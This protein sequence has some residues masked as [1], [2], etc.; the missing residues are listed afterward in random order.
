V[1]IDERRI[2]VDRELLDCVVSMAVSRSPVP[3]QIACGLGGGGPAL[4]HA[5]LAV[6]GPGKISIAEMG[7][8]VCYRGEE[9]CVVDCCEQVGL[10]KEIYRP[11]L[12][13][14][15]W[16][17]VLVRDTNPS[18]VS[19]AGIG[20]PKARESL[21]TTLLQS[22][23]P[24]S[25]DLIATIF[26]QVGCATGLIEDLALLDPALLGGSLVSRGQLLALPLMRRLRCEITGAEARAVL[27]I[28]RVLCLMDPREM[29][30]SDEWALL[31]SALSNRSYAISD[32]NLVLGAFPGLFSLDGDARRAVVRPSSRL[33]VLLLLGDVPV[34]PSEHFAI[35]KALRDRALAMLERKDTSDR[36]VA[37]QLPRQARAAA[38]LHDLV[39]DPL[40]VLC[41][42]PLELVRE[43][44]A[45]PSD[46][47]TPAGKIVALSS[48]R[49]ID[50]PDRASQLELSARRIGLH[51][52]ADELAELLPARRWRALWAQSELTHTHRVAFNHRAPLLAV[53]AVDHPEGRAY[54]GSADGRVWRVAPYRRPVCLA[55]S[56]ALSVEIRAIAAVRVADNDLVGVG[57][58]SHAVGVFDGKSGRLLW[59]D[60]TSHSD[61]VSAV[62]IQGDEEPILLSAGVGG[63]IFRH[64]MAA[65][66]EPL[67]IHEHGSEIRDLRTI[68][69]GGVELVV[70]CAVNGVV[71]VARLKDGVLVANWHL[72]DEV[73]NSVAV[74]LLVDELLLIAG[75]SDGSLRQLRLPLC[76]LDCATSDEPPARLEEWQRIGSHPLAVNRVHIVADGRQP[77]VLSGASDGSWQ[78]RHGDVEERAG[79]G[80]VGPIWSLDLIEA[81]NRRYVVTAGGEGACRLWLTDAVL[82]ERI[83]N[84][85]PLAHRGPVSAIQ[86]AA[87]PAEETLVVT[88][89]ADGDVRVAAR[90]L[91]EGGELLTRHDSGISALACLS[92]GHERS[93]VVSGS[94]DGTLRLTPVDGRRRQDSVVLGIAHE[95]IGALSV[96]M[97]EDRQTLISGGRDGTVTAWD[98]RECFADKTVQGCRYGGVQALCHIDDQDGGLL[99]VGGQE[100]R[101]GMLRGSGLEEQ[102][103]CSIETSVLCLS[104][105]PGASRTVLAG[106]VDGRIAVVRELGLY[107]QQVSY[108]QACENEIRG[109]G[110]LVLGGRVFVA[111][112]GLDRRLRLIDIQ[113]EEPTMDIEMDGYA[114]SLSAVGA[115]VGLGSSAGAAVICFPT[116]TLV[117]NQ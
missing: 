108:L 76:D 37:R 8:A 102:G 14:S 38:A 81:G 47:R 55:G 9:G 57:T 65:K 92:L 71:G 39:S 116:D 112:A 26:Q 110:T 21:F 67:V 48:H 40:A 15:G 99:V 10:A 91:T 77:A 96:G 18:T 28:G 1:K 83:M 58:S 50:A 95:G 69:I 34:S 41:S 78:W 107:G 84:A 33:A 79:L 113:T 29:E 43:L 30:L 101:L 62:A 97:L 46:M 103:A 7:S 24:A 60:E 36:F 5:L 80:H 72:A 64:P 109:L 68:S 11:H 75:T 100:G 23:W 44:E 73:L 94:I 16:C 17:V 98:L 2:A 22:R 85:Q 51:A 6:G 104:P 111:C 27:D 115:S 105:L 86:L 87:D 42:D 4:A 31:A 63:V 59:L 117:L 52:F 89:G 61:P 93:H 56:S 3:L 49:L 12:D 19:L 66:G 82:D 54:V 35:Y 70:F 74:R 114:L 25:K 45:H 88:G 106:L 13:E 53:A 20:L 90:D 32:I